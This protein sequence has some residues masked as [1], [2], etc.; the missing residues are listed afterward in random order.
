MGGRTAI[1]KWLAV[2]AC[3]AAPACEMGA[4]GARTDRSSVETSSAIAAAPTGSASGAGKAD[5]GPPV[6]QSCGEDPDVAVFFSPRDPAPAGPLRVVVVSERAVDGSLV[7]TVPGDSPAVTSKERRGGPPF[8]WLAEIAQAK[9][10]EHRAALQAPGVHVCGQI[11]VGPPQNARLSGGPRSVW[12]VEQ[13][14]SRA[15]ENLYSDWI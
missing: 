3:V 10:G 12:P 2:V 5:A 6:P 9:A 15:T 11:T 14:W 8:F 13:P 1:L 4:E 7:L